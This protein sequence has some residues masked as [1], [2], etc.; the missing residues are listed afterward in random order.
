MNHNFSR[1]SIKIEIRWIWGAAFSPVQIL[2]ERVG[3]GATKESVPTRLYATEVC[4]RLAGFFYPRTRRWG[5]A[6]TAGQSSGSPSAAPQRP[7][8]R[9][10]PLA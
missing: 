6:D 7:G 3:H 9:E 5:T 1:E 8:W 10:L 2:K 4:A